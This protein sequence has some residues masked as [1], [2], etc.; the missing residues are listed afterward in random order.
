MAFTSAA[1]LSFLLIVLLSARFAGEVTTVR[2]VLLL[3]AS[4]FFYA[5]WNPVLLILLVFLSALF[6]LAALT[7][8]TSSPNEGRR[9]LAL[10]VGVALAGLAV[11]KYVG[12]F[13]DTGVSLAAL[14]GLSLP[15]PVVEI[16]LPVGISF[17]TFAGIAYVVDVWR[18]KVPA[19][20]SFVNT[21]LFVGFFPAVVAGPIARA[22]D[23]MPQLRFP[24]AADAHA[25][26][27][28]LARILLGLGKKLLLADLLGAHLVDRV[29]D[30][31][32]RFSSLE[33]LAAA[34]GYAF[35]IY[36]DF[37]GY[38]DIAIGSAGL[39]GIQLGE[40]FDAPYRA[41]NLRDFWRRWHISLSKWLRDYL[42]VPLGGSRDGGLVASLL[43]TMGLGGLWHGAAW[44]FVAWG[45]VH[46][47]GLVMTHVWHDARYKRPYYREGSLGLR[48]VLAWAATFHLVTAAWVLFRA[49]SFDNAL[50]LFGQIL[51]GQPGLDNLSSTAL[52]LLA[53]SVAV[54]AFPR[55][56]LA[57]LVDGFALLPSPAQAALMVSA[58]WVMG[59]LSS[60]AVSPFVY[61]QF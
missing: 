31:P 11:F 51:A 35:Q 30:L 17:Y 55:R 42:Y 48:K 33:A 19:E 34:Y 47:V 29:F 41:T 27:R 59:R 21:A 4:W 57:R 12:F 7:I 40:N 13:V 15:R 43:I 3:T 6:H 1:Y 52:W 23:L 10:A 25:E 50:A 39:L 14:V 24:P 49:D 54:L 16:A 18:E 20:P 44:T 36:F 8:A 37:S 38:T 46:G 61:V 58:A 2:N 28:A 60:G 9:V 32:D 56:V 26:G 5:C 22:G 53:A 45:L